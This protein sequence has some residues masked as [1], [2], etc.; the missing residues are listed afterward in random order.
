MEQ[1]HFLFSVIVPVYNVE[2]YLDETIRSIVRQTI[3]F[4]ENIELI[5]VNNGTMDGSGLICEKYKSLYPNNVKYIEL[6][7]NVG[8]SGARNIGIQH[9]TG[10]YIDFLDSDDKWG[11]SAFEK[12]SKLFQ[13]YQEINIMACREKRFDAIE[14]WHIFDYI[15]KKGKEIIDIFED[16]DCVWFASHSLIFR[17]EILEGYQFDE[18]LSDSEDMK[19]V[20]QILLKEQRYGL[21]S[22]AVYYYRERS[23][24]SSLVQNYTKKK[25]WY[26]EVLP[27]VTSSLLEL[28]NR[29]YGECVPY[30]RW[31]IMF[32]LQ[33]RTRA[34]LP[35]YFTVEECEKYREIVKDLLQLIDD[36]IILN[37]RL[38]NRE[39]K[40]NVLNLKYGTEFVRQIEFQ[41][42]K[43]LFQ[44]ATIL[45]TRD[46]GCLALELLD[47]SNGYMF[48]WGR[49]SLP[50]LEDENS[51]CVKDEQENVYDYTTFELDRSFL[52]NRVAPSVPMR[53]GLLFRIPLNQ[54]KRLHFEIIIGGKSY[55]LGFRFGR[56]FPL[57]RN[58]GHSH[59][60]RC[61]WHI[62]AE[63]N[64]LVIVRS[65]FFHRTKKQLDLWFELLKRGKK[66]ALLAHMYAYLYSILPKIHKIWI[67][68]DRQHYAGDNGE[69]MYRYVNSQNNGKIKTYFV[70][71]GNS[72]DFERMKQ[73]G[74]VVANKTWKYY[75]LF[76][77]ADMLI[78]SHFDR[79]NVYP[80]YPV[81][82]EYV[83]DL[84]KHRFIY[85][86]HGVIKDNLCR[87]NAKLHTNVSCFIVS[88]Y[89]EYKS[90][91]EYPYGYAE[92]D[93]WL[94]G[95]ARYDQ[96]YNCTSVEGQKV[97][98]IAPT[99]RNN[100]RNL[101]W[102]NG[103]GLIEYSPLFRETEYFRFYHALLNDE[104][105]LE[106]MRQYGYKGC[107][108]LHPL[109][110]YFVKEFEG[111]EVFSIEVSSPGYREE[112]AQTSL[113]VTDYSSIA[114]D[115]AYAYKPCVYAQFDA[116]TFYHGHTYSQGYFCY[117]RDGFGP[118]CYDY[119]STVQAIIRA[120]KNGC[121]M[122]DVYRKRAEKF[123]PFRDGKCCERIYQK[124][125]EIEN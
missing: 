2:K 78:A 61:G 110:R 62:R 68:A 125:L 86:Q 33:G 118:V 101:H 42:G 47:V 21:A 72:P 19:Y 103:D 25:Y 37:Q 105:I 117:E 34:E 53:K 60:Y 26:F 65:R 55:P 32:N 66:K 96:I 114:F 46:T 90:L 23:D 20:N 12:V 13:K 51:F 3:G 104:R 49:S 108:R 64:E 76:F 113:L 39:Q 71:D 99:W 121:V 100:M 45:T 93:V 38:L 29:L 48:I 67:F 69:W 75:S 35:D 106:T 6:Q 92:K 54:A 43:F 56:F 102:H 85:L 84:F 120:I 88:G 36:D 70:L 9:A 5:L 77:R 79:A 16:P 112:I 107:F 11:L 81:H 109:L 74:S 111:N 89:K 22:E 1:K 115:Y 24:G 17:R 31:L 15:F 63:G 94:S 80:F 122:E 28:S 52:D 40:I 83:K 8:P 7:K 95:L 123:F 98:L 10:E 4:Q 73:F 87:D 82:E 14:G 59:Y 27:N 91:L 30:L 18:S 50:E 41:D 57:T 116:D 97:V 44:G 58:L 124:I 119:D